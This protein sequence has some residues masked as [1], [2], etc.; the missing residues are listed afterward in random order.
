MV[1]SL[2]REEKPVERWTRQ[3]AKDSVLENTTGAENTIEMWDTTGMWDRVKIED[4]GRL[5]T[6][7]LRAARNATVEESWGRKN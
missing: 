7:R 4:I 6:R 5:F 3:G 2:G 1:K